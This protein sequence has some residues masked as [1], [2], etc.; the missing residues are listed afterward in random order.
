MIDRAK[1]ITVLIR[2]NLETCE[3]FPPAY[4][5]NVTSSDTVLDGHFDLDRLGE[6]VDRRLKE[7]GL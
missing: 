4:V 1:L 2:E 5:D 7:E 3:A 6:I